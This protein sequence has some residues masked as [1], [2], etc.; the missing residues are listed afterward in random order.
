M[1]KLYMCGNNTLLN[2]FT[3]AIV[4]TIPHTFML[5][6]NMLGDISLLSSIIIAIFT[7]K[8]KKKRKQIKEIVFIIYSMNDNLLG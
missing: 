5:G 1:L 7:T 6:I 8:S 2:T 4:T 3:I